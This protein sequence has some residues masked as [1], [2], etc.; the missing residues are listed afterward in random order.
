MNTFIRLAKANARMFGAKHVAALFHEASNP[1]KV[2]SRKYMARSSIFFRVVPQ[3]DV[4]A[5]KKNL[6]AMLVHPDVEKGCV[7]VKGLIYFD[8]SVAGLEGG[9]EHPHGYARVREHGNETRM[10]N[11]TFVS[12]PPKP[13]E[14]K[15]TRVTNLL[16]LLSKKYLSSRLVT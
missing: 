15:N 7:G 6:G 16:R 5:D 3:L 2:N 13:F 1:N 4:S 10:G 8:F 12:I 14:T 11:K 9:V